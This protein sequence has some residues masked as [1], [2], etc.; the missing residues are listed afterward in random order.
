[1]EADV[2]L[3]HSNSW[4]SPPLGVW[5]DGEEMS[6]D[7]ARLLAG[8]LLEAAAAAGTVGCVPAPAQHHETHPT[9]EG[10]NR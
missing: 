10:S 3:Y 2:E 6:L 7:E 9:T 1:M 5:V 8:A 4:S